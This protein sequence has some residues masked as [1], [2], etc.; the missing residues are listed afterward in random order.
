MKND[1][2]DNHCLRLGKSLTVT[3]VTSSHV[4]LWQQLTVTKGCT[5]R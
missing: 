2:V 1:E 3:K 4:F 5:S